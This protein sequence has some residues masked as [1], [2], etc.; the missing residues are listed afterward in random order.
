MNY[1][2]R[3]NHLFQL[4][5]RCKLQFF[6]QVVRAQNLNNFCGHVQKSEMMNWQYKISILSFSDRDEYITA[7]HILPHWLSTFSTLNVCLSCYNK[8]S[9]YM[10]YYYHIPL[11]AFFGRPFVKRFALCYQT[12]VCLSVLSCLSVTL[13]CGGQMVGWIKMKPDMQVGLGPGD[14]LLYGDWGPSSPPTKK[15]QPPSN[16]R[17]M[18]ICGQTAGWMKTPLGMEVDLGPGHI[19]LDGDPAPSFQPMP[20]VTTVTHLSYCWS[21]VVDTMLFTKMNKILLKF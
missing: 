16:F 8:I 18:S 13:V 19:V 1:T 9:S 21:F 20:I 11:L 17:P 5:K 15:A 7:L 3:T 12:V 10:W 2:W 6:D 14:F 4:L